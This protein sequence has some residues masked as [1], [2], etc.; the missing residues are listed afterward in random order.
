MTLHA[1]TLGC[2]NS[3]QRSYGTHYAVELQ[4]LA[5]AR[6][7][8][9]RVKQQAGSLKLPWKLRAPSALVP[10]AAGRGSASAVGQLQIAGHCPLCSHFFPGATT[11][12]TVRHEPPAPFVSRVASL[13]SSRGG[14]LCDEATP[15]CET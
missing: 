7:C 8:K 2:R 12:S 11:K 4:A 5:P 3:N 10:L 6:S 13:K 9:S 14:I 15:P 1:S